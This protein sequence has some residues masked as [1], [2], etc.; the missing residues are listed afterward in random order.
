MSK[1]IIHLHEK[2]RRKN[3]H[4]QE[5]EIYINA[6]GRILRSL[7]CRKKFTRIKEKRKCLVLDQNENKHLIACEICV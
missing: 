6:F 1:V 4:T 5:K 3:A 7:N 2:G